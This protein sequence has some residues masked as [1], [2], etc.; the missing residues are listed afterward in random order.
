MM[1]GTRNHEDKARAEAL[2]KLAVELGV[3]VSLL[4]FFTDDRIMSIYW[5]MRL[6]ERLWLD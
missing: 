2:R 6:M 5:R 3:S 4:R 1:G